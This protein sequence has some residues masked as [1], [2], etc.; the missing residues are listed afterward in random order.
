[1]DDPTE[2]ARPSLP[3]AKV[4][5]EDGLGAG[6]TRA[7]ESERK[8]RR[9]AERMLR[10]TQAR[11]SELESAELR[12]DV[13]ASRKLTPTQAQRLMGTTREEL[14]ADADDLVAAFAPP[15]SARDLIGGS[16][17]ENLRPGAAPGS[18]AFDAG[19]VAD[20]ILDRG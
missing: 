17:R 18:E 19:K 1:M 16:P 9:E 15:P 10:E 20:R 6:G 7:L 12:R 2:G 14:E 5:A 4:P 11:V 8:A 3:A 13:A